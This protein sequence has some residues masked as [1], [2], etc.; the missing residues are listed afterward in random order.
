MLI[1]GGTTGAQEVFDCLNPV[2]LK[3]FSDVLKLDK[4]SR[5]IYGIQVTDAD[6]IENVDSNSP[7]F[8]KQD[9]HARPFNY[10][11]SDA[12][13]SVLLQNTSVLYTGAYWD[14]RFPR[15]LPLSKKIP[16]KV[17]FIA[18]VAC[19]VKGGEEEMIPVA[20]I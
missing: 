1:V 13:Y 14:S 16:K 5:E 19:D 9:Y 18:D 17:L 4:E 12:F 8:R 20:N 6:V 3:S 7:F 11:I 15:W 10:K 2:R